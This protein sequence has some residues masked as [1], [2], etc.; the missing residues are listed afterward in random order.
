[1]KNLRRILCVLVVATLWSLRAQDEESSADDYS[2]IPDF[3]DE[4]L[5]TP[6]FEVTIGFRGVSGAKSSF[7]G[8]A[9]IGRGVDTGPATGANLNRRYQ[10]GHVQADTR[11]IVDANGNTVLLQSVSPDGLTNNWDY[12]D[13]SQ[14]TSDGYVAMHTYEASINPATVQ[15]DQPSSLGVE[16]LVTRDMGKLFGTRAR[17]SVIGGFSVNDISGKMDTEETASVVTNTDYFS[18]NGQSAPA[19]GTTSTGALLDSNPFR[20]DPTTGTGLVNNHWKLKGAYMAFRVGP[21][22]TIPITERLSASFS[23]GGV[24]TYAGSNYTV[25]QTFLPQTGDAIVD[26]VSD[27]A[28]NIMPGF[29]ADANINFNINERSGLYMGTLYQNSGSYRQTISHGGDNPDTEYT[30]KVDLGSLQGVRAGMSFKF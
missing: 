10:D 15:K 27:G 6:K 24:L 29:Y 28:S 12:D 25:V 9:I 23:V 18:L 16:L 26:A 13:E 1:M 4:I 19:A 7:G 3:S 8:R 17:W 5:Y 11:T 2:P 20:A 14:I 21:S 30:T 22:L